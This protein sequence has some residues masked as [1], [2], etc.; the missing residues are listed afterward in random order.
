MK[1]LYGL[2]PLSELVAPGEMR[3]L[4]V[5]L[6]IYVLGGAIMAILNVALGW[7]P[8]LGLLTQV[9]STLMTIYCL[10]GAALAVVRFWREP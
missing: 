5:T 4:A 3:S 7:I 8:I 1:A 2:F 9:A 6:V 10:V